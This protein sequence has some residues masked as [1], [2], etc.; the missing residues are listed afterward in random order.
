VSEPR[1]IRLNVHEIPERIRRLAEESGDP[2]SVARA[3]HRFLAGCQSAL[4]PHVAVGVDRETVI[5][6]ISPRAVRGTRLGLEAA[7]GLESRAEAE[8]EPI[9]GEIA[10]DEA[11]FEIEVSGDFE[12]ELLREAIRSVVRFFPLPE[13][14]WFEICEGT[15]ALG[16]GRVE[17]QTEYE[18]LGDTAGRHLGGHEYGCDAIVSYGRDLWWNVPCLRVTTERRA[19]RYGWTTGFTELALEFDIEQWLKTLADTAPQARR[20]HIP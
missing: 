11:E 7:L 6:N 4:M 10:V 17:F 12:G 9:V 19:Y 8:R 2:K 20:A 14:E 5:I 13:A 18:T 16:Q 15:L 3:V 1:Q